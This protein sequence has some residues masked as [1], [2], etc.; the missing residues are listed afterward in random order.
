MGSMNGGFSLP[1]QAMVS[2]QLEQPR[3]LFAEPLRQ[4]G[5]APGPNAARQVTVSVGPS[6][7]DWRSRGLGSFDLLSAQCKKVISLSEVR[8]LP[9]ALPSSMVKRS[10]ISVVPIVDG[11]RAS[12][13]YRFNQPAIAQ[14]NQ[15]WVREAGGWRR[16]KC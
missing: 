15:P 14:E 3:L 9:L 2:R 11:D 6:R 10:S 1:Y 5:R 8:L 7:T 12:V 13:S 16:D 4:K